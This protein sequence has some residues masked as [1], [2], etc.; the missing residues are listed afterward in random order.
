MNLSI[1][2]WDTKLINLNC[3]TETHVSNK[4][5]HPSGK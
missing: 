2:G 3:V 1:D 5:E 4:Y